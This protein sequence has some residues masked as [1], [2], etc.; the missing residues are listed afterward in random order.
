MGRG[1]RRCT[2]APN[3]WPPD[4]HR[5]PRSSRRVAQVGEPF[6]PMSGA[7]ARNCGIRPIRVHR[8]NRS[9][10]ARIVRRSGRAPGDTDQEDHHQENGGTARAHR[11]KSTIPL[12]MRNLPEGKSKCKSV[13]RETQAFATQGGANHMCRRRPADDVLVELLTRSRKPPRAESCQRGTPVP[14]SAIGS[15]IGS[16]SLHI[17]RTNAG[18]LPARMKYCGR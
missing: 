8:K 16:Q 10:A 7:A 14:A 15:P 18:A 9:H 5:R 13:L 2:D 17:D 6:Q 1:R 12:N 11:R 4:S 3:W